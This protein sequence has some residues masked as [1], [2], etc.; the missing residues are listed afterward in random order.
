MGIAGVVLTAR[1][2]SASPKTGRLLEL[3]TIAAC[4]IGGASLMGE[5]GSIPG[6]VL[7]TLVMESLNNDMNM[8]NMD[9]L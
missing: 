9:V 7:G 2:G 6:A 1:V 5:R 3:D 8:A 4:V